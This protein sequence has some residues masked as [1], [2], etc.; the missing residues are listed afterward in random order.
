MPE[1]F[2]GQPPGTTVLPCG[3]PAPETPAYW[4]EIELVGEDGGPIAFEEY[5][6]VLP[7]GKQ[8]PGLLDDQGVARLEGLTTGG[9][10][11]IQFPNL[12]KDAWESIATLGGRE[13]PV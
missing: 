7:D 3:L 6:V 8:A 2:S 11:Q 9:T 12:D 13:K 4:V 1:S 10:C 5:L